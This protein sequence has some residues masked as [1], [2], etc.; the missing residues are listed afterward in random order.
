MRH[1]RLMGLA[2]I[3]AASLAA[4]GAWADEPAPTPS[5]KADKSHTTT[6][7][8]QAKDSSATKKADPRKTAANTSKDRP[9]CIKSTGSR[10]PAR[11]GECLSE[12]GHSWSR[13][14][15]ESTGK[16]TAGGAL[17]QMDPLLH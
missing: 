4:S 15:V 5:P 3:L 7:T 17:R 6:N 10:I 2:V 14:D 11:P 12:P 9:N 13:D 16:T 1:T 8:S